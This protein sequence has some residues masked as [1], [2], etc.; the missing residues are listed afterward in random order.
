VIDDAA[1]GN[2]DSCTYSWCFTKDVTAPTPPTN[3]VAKPGHNKVHLSWQN[4]TSSDVV[5]VKLQRVPWTNYPNY[6]TIPG[7]VSAPAY[8]ASQL[9]GTNVFDSAASVTV[10]V[11]HDDIS[12]LSNATRDIYYYGAFAYDVAGNYSVAA[13]TAQGRAT[14]Y[15]LGDVSDNTVSPNTS[16]GFVYLEDLALFSIAYAT[17][18][19][20]AAFYDDADFGPTFGGS[21]KGIPNPDDSIQF[22]DLVIFAINFDAVNPSMKAVPIFADRSVNGDLSLTVTGEQDG[23]VTI[24]RLNL[25][26]N[27][28]DIKALRITL[29]FDE[30]S[31]LDK[32][33]LNPS[34]ANAAQPIF[35]KILSDKGGVTIDA[36]V[37]GT[38]YTIGGSGELAILRF[39]TPVGTPN[40]ILAEGTLRD[41]DNQSLSAALVSPQIRVI[42]DSYSLAQNYPN[43]FNPS[44]EIAYQI[45]SDGHVRLEVFNM[46]GQSVTVLVDEHKVAGDHSVQWNGADLRGN[47]VASGIYLY[48]LSTP[49]YS[50]TRKMMLVK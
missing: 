47:S 41:R 33:E 2:A 1:R 28:G 16:D 48:R 37:L 15:W 24:Y 19:G 13:A 45:P 20:D 7:P 36:A 30:S 21:P 44:T 39:T 43:P 18:Q 32:V 11:T 29:A 46:L 3:L 23:N 35:T 17:K 22:E 4:S 10:N 31:T 49:A 12:G 14:S 9:V 25:L 5:G 42:P 34:L 40:L 6:G 50:A 38:G 27:R 8:P 26:N